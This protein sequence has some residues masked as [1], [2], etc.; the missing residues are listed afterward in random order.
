MRDTPS[1]YK[2]SRGSSVRYSMF[3]STEPESARLE[4]TVKQPTTTYGPCKHKVSRLLLRSIALPISLSGHL[5]CSSPSLR[6][7]PMN[8]LRQPP[9]IKLHR[10]RAISLLNQ[11]GHH[12]NAHRTTVTQVSKKTSPAADTPTY[13][14]IGNPFFAA[15]APNFPIASKKAGSGWPLK[16]PSR[17]KPA[18]MR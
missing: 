8:Q 1:T 5:L 13:P 15:A 12:I 10:N 3:S 14:N 7:R 6:Q 18:S 17:S 11:H 2:R 9:N 4:R 16:A